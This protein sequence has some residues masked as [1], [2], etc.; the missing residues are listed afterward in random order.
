MNYPFDEAIKRIAWLG[1]G[2]VEIYNY[3]VME[4]RFPTRI[5]EHAPRASR[6]CTASEKLEAAATIEQLAV[7][8]TEWDV[9]KVSDRS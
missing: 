7:R 3:G 9:V 2:A 1:Y 4:F 8:K 5:R 6:D